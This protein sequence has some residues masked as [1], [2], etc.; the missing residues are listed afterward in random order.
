MHF[1]FILHLPLHVYLNHTSTLQFHHGPLGVANPL[2][3]NLVLSQEHV[4][5]MKESTCHPAEIQCHY[6]KVL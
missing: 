5:K 1:S 4:Y 6:L 2:R 3:I